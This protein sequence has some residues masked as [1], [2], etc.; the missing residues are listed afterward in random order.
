MSL[1]ARALLISRCHNW[2]RWR[3]KNMA[4]VP[5]IEHT[6]IA[7]KC[8]CLTPPNANCQK[9][10]SW[11]GLLRILMMSARILLT[12]MVE[13][14]LLRVMRLKIWHQPHHQPLTTHRTM[15]QMMAQ[16]KDRIIDQMTQCWS[17][18]LR[19]KR[20]DCSKWMTHPTP[21]KSK[22]KSTKK[23]NTK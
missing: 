2:R 7:N 15:A 22:P 8:M 13:I 9:K 12:R 3:R 14:R 23:S 18:S 21:P 1:A 16:M 4:V 19:L 17:C 20:G 6:I 11:I 10:E 5:H